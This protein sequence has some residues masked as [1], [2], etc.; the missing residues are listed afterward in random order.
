VLW[1]ADLESPLATRGRCGC[2]N[3]R[4]FARAL[5]RYTFN[6][7]VKG[8]AAVGIQPFGIVVLETVGRRSG[9][10]RRTPVGGHLQD[11]SVWLV[12][13]HGRQADYVRNIE[14]DPHVRVKVKRKWRRGVARLLP[15]DDWRDRLR[16]MGRG[17]P[18]LRMTLALTRM[19]ATEAVTVRIGLDHGEL[20][21]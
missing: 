11:D 18:G 7:L 19:L 21:K 16:A 17:R 14:A 6:A 2:V 8:G 15:E 12:A 3:R 9:K 1:G 20:S 4:R 13:E 5:D 10:L